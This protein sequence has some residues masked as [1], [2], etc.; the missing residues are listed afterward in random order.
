MYLTDVGSLCVLLLLNFFDH[1]IIFANYV[2]NQSELKYKILQKKKPLNGS[3]K[4]SYVGGLTAQVL[5]NER[6][7]MLEKELSFDWSPNLHTRYV[8]SCSHSMIYMRMDALF[9]DVVL[10]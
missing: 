7:E 10:T 9:I 4:W 8:S 2:I 3:G 5:T 6:I 1:S